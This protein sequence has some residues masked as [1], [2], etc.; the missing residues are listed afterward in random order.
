VHTVVYVRAAFPAAVNGFTSP[1]EN[2]TEPSVR[3]DFP[4]R[5]IKQ[6]QPDYKVLENC[7][8]STKGHAEYGVSA[9]AFVDSILSLGI[10]VVNVASRA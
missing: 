2:R 5:H 6:G 7:T 9:E 3:V 1:N 4:I 8:G 10:R